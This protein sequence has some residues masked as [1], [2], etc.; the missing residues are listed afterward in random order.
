MK[1]LLSFAW[2]YQLYQWLVGA[3]KYSRLFADE[4]IRYI[5]GQSILDIGCGPADILH[6]LPL[7]ADYTGID[8]SQ[9]YV[10]KARIAHPKQ[11]FICGDIGDPDFPLPDQLF[12]TVFLIGV[13]HHLD[14]EVVHT[15][16]EFAQRKLKPGGRMLCL[17]PV[18]ISGQGV[19]ERWFMRNDR[20]K[21]IRDESGYVN[22][23]RAHF[24]ETRADIK[25]HTMNIP[26]T[27]IIMEASKP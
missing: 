19:I 7:D 17:E 18:W 13:Q 3:N 23:M 21:Y 25:P 16:F 8:L 4:Y 1:K 9:H 6:Y 24:K 27:I 10:A 2:I 22:L 12:D 20:G 26:F 14:D 15:M 11:R 5:D